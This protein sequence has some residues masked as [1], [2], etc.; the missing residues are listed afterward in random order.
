[1]ARPR[2]T[3]H[4][5]RLTLSLYQEDY[6]FLV[7]HMGP[8]EKISHFILDAAYEHVGSNA[9]Y[10][11]I[12]KELHEARAKKKEL[13]KRIYTKAEPNPR[14]EINEQELIKFYNEMEIHKAISKT[15]AVNWQN[16]F[17]KNISILSSMGV[18]DYKDLQLWCI[19]HFKH[20]GKGGL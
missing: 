12:Y 13:E 9:R 10:D 11:K 14:I 7:D 18:N 15:G 19:E 17:D 20:N 1:M 2:K 4:R 6:D 16:L 3:I 8:N 5:I